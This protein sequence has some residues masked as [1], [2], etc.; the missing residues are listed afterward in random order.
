MSALQT[1]GGASPPSFEGSLLPGT[2]NQRGATYQSYLEG[3][4][5]EGGR[6]YI[7]STYIP[8][9]NA[10]FGNRDKRV[11]KMQMEKI[12]SREMNRS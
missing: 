10:Y 12:N 3:R 5:G 4:G 1:G 11:H 9:Q 2:P 8:Y 7:P 6:E